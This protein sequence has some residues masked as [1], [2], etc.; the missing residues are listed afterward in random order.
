MRWR[1]Y[2]G[3]R[4]FTRKFTD[5]T[6]WAER[7]DRPITPIVGDKLPLI[8]SLMAGA[9]GWL[10][11]AIPSGREAWDT[12]SYFTMFVPALVLFAGALGFLVPRRAWRWGLA[13]FAGQAAAAVVLNPTGGLLP[14]GLI[15]FGFLSV[16][17]VIS[18][19][20]GAFISRR[21]LR[22]EQLHDLP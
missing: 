17:A 7:T 20:L 1:D 22:R 21:L 6:L 12:S 3:G 13:L 18:A 11:L 19:T 4:G 14:L 5:G 9:C 16:P 10:A 2:N 8:L 15:V